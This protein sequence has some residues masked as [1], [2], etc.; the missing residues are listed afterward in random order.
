MVA[1]KTTLL[2]PLTFVLAVFLFWFRPGGIDGP[3]VD[4][5]PMKGKGFDHSLLSKVYA[6][7]VDEAGEVDYA[8]LKAQPDTLDRY[9]G[10]IAATSPKNAP[11][12]FRSI[13]DRL[14][15]Y[16]NAYN[17]F[18]LAAVRDHCPIENV[19]DEYIG[20]GFF[21][22]VS[23][24]MGGESITLTRLQSERIRPVMQRNPS[25]H[26]ALV[27]GAKGHL[28]PSGYAFTGPS[29]KQQ[30]NSLEQRVIMDSRF[31]EKQNGVLNLSKIFEWYKSDFIDPKQW[32]G[33]L[34]PDKIDGVESVRFRPFDWNLNGRCP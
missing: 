34:A 32:V 8:A 6:Q 27:G 26:F 22:R 23:F 33:R 18:V 29:L 30:L 2:V 11:H 19:D 4:P 25:V 7:V 28:S 3:R 14:A 5:I 20:G 16:L 15:Y 24:L 17:A 13:D 21:W 31:V 1:T 12:R 9:L 10:H